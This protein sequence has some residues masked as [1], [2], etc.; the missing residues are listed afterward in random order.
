MTLPR[1]AGLL[2]GLM[3]M[4]ACPGTTVFVDAAHPPESITL[5][6]EA[7]RVERR[8]N[9][10]ALPKQG[11]K[12]EFGPFKVSFSANPRWQP[13]Q[14]VGPVVEPW[15][16]VRLVDERDGSVVA[17]QVTVLRAAGAQEVLYGG[18]EVCGEDVKRCEATYRLELERQGP[19][20]GGV[21]EVEWGVD[22]SAWVSDTRDGDLEVRISPSEP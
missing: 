6:A 21:V 7:P 9:V 3:L 12:V 19:P 4:T 15:V 13:P 16:R 10:T 17:E 20:S 2:G 8:L 5:T 11:E 22:V 18:D 1:T 14:D